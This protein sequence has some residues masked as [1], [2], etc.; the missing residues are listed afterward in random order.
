MMQIVPLNSSFT[1]LNQSLPPLK[2][3][4]IIKRNQ[5]APLLCSRTGTSGIGE[6]V[7]CLVCRAKT[8]GGSG[9]RTAGYLNGSSADNSSV[10]LRSSIASTCSSSDHCGDLE[11]NLP[12]VAGDFAHIS[13]LLLDDTD[14]F[15]VEE[16]EPAK[17]VPPPSIDP[18]DLDLNRKVENLLYTLKDLLPGPV[19]KC[20]FEREKCFAARNLFHFAVEVQDPLVCMTGITSLQQ[21]LKILAT[22]GAMVELHEILHPELYGISIETMGI[23]CLDAFFHRKPGTLI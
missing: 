2:K 20:G 9:Y 22:T 10:R 21:W 6:A 15:E 13:S 1:C 5:P 8:S 16:K 12:N 4:G 3:L 11:D 7:S 14:A 23:C 17:Y 19:N 18:S